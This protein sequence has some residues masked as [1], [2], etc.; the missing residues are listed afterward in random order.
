MMSS[1]Q[2][3]RNYFGIDMFFEKPAVGIFA[4]KKLDCTIHVYTLPFILFLNVKRSIND[5]SIF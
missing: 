5:Y 2:N 3:Y 1:K 4:E